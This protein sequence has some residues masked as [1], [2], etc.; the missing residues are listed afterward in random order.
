VLYDPY[1]RLPK[2]AS[3]E[4]L[5]EDVRDGEQISLPHLS[6]IFGA[7]GQDLSP[8]LSWGGFPEG[9][10]SFV[11]TMYDPDAPTGSGFWH[12]AVVDIPANVTSLARGV[13]EENGSTL[14][15]DAFH[16]R[17]D[18]G[19]AGYVGAAP[20]PGHGKHHYHIVVHAV[21]IESLGLDRNTTPALLGFNL[22]SHSLG[23]AR[24]VLWHER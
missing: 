15:R 10:K 4:V 6:G 16:L 5:S 9:T 21:D 1:E 22:F 24:M 11:V 20:P 3:F 14:P 19:L 18:A 23:R 17:N 8:Q 2:V 7:G 13:G 12:W